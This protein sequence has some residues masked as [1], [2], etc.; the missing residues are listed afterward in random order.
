VSTTVTDPAGAAAPGRTTRRRPPGWRERRRDRFLAIATPIVL[1]GVWELAAH[2]GWI[3]FRY[4]PAP[5][6]IIAKGIELTRNGMLADQVLITLW[7][8]ALGLLIGGVPAI[9][10]G[11]AM[12]LYRPLRAM[13]DPLIAATYP[14]PRSALLPLII[15]LFGLGESA[16]VF[17]VALGA[18]YPIVINTAVGMATIPRIYFDV[19]HN[20][21]AK[22]LRLFRTV[23]LPGALPMIM[24]GVRL[25]VGLALIMIVIAE[26]FGAEE[27]LGFL[28]WNSWQV[29]AIET[30]YVGLL[31]IGILGYLV[32]LITVTAERRLV[33]WVGK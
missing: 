1:L 11:L 27:G 28:L 22:G 4:F 33:P 21:G 8:L 3:D 16:K 30:M 24:S 20:Y 5:S 6:E 15:L 19:A 23:A 18:F 14:I 12:G 25:G 10:L 2:A 9:L 31:T 7:R 32:N 13:L 17:M 26:M 29:F